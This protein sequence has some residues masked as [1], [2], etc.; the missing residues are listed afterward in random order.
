MTSKQEVPKRPWWH[1]RRVGALVGGALL[2]GMATTIH[3]WPKPDVPE[4]AAK[5]AGSQQVI[6]DA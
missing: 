4:A 3:Q 6:R 1:P 5:W 2:G